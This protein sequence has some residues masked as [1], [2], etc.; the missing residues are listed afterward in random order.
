MEEADISPSG[1]FKPSTPDKS[2]VSPHSA[3]KNEKQ[4]VPKE[5]FE[6]KIALEWNHRYSFI[7]FQPN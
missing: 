5:V 3:V 1:P 2:P 7:K 6:P 4:R